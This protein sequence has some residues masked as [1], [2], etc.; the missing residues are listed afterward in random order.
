MSPIS[1]PDPVLR[2][3]PAERGSG[4][5]RCT[6]ACGTDRGC[7]HEASS[8]P[9]AWRDLSPDFMP[10]PTPSEPTELAGARFNARPPGPVER[11]SPIPSMLWR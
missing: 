6:R 8:A 5:A 1:A 2:R 4:R 7:A 3:P 11:A 9:S 10:V